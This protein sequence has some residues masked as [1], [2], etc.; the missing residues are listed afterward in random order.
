MVTV[1]TTLAAVAVLATAQMREPTVPFS[2]ILAQWS[3]TLGEVERYLDGADQ[4]EERTV[5]YVDRVNAIGI[6]AAAAVAAAR[7]EIETTEQLLAALGEEAT[8]DR[9]GAVPESGSVIRRRA[10]LQ[11]QLTIL[12][13]R[14]ALADLTVARVAQLEIALSQQ[15]RS[16]FLDRLRRSAPMPLAPNTVAAAVPEFIGQVQAVL[17]SP[18]AWYAALPPDQRTVASLAPPL[19]PLLVAVVLAALAR[20]LLLRWFGQGSEIANPTYARR[21][22]AA[23][24]E[25]AARGI[26]PASVF[27]VLA[28]RVSTGETPFTGHW[29]EVVV[30]FA[31]M[32]SFCLLVVSAPRAILAPEN[33]AYRLTA[34]KPENTRTISRRLIVLATI[35]A[36]DFF[37]ISAGDEAAVSDELESLYLFI[38][39]GAAAVY[40]VL[41][42]S[43]GLWSV[44]APT[45]AGTASKIGQGDRGERFWHW[46]RGLSRLIALFALLA[47]VF[48]FIA[49]GSYLIEALLLTGLIVGVLLLVRGLFRET[50]GL[51]TRSAFVVEQL[52]LRHAARKAMKFWLRAALD[53]LMLFAAVAMILPI[54]GVP[55]PELRRW[56][57]EVLEGIAI[58]EVAISPIDI[59][60][61]VVAF[62]VVLA[63]SRWLRRS[64]SENILPQLEMEPGLQNSLATGV[65]YIGIIVAAALGIAVMGIDLTSLALIFGALSVGIG[66]GLQNIVNNFVSGFVLLI[67]RPIIVGDWVVIGPHEGFVKQINPRSTEIET[68]Q[69]ASVIV[70]NAD[71]IS[72]AVTNWTHTDK[73][74]RIEVRVHVTRSSN[75]PRVR[76]ILLQIANEHPS[77]LVD[78]EPFV[79]FQDFNPSSLEFELRCYTN[80][81]IWKLNIASDMRYEIDRR[82]RAEGIDIPFPRYIVRAEQAQPAADGDHADTAEETLPVEPIAPDRT[83]SGA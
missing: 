43:A 57:G 6:E 10:D 12:Q 65:G 67:E 50:I 76:D 80:D 62:A 55:W 59:L 74:G 66:F 17:A 40:I 13:S 45:A 71:F 52:G 4:T 77:V 18:L 1:F 56:L 70:P 78:P 54:W 29:A 79:L 37:L 48:G 8:P 53:L 9:G 31:W 30:A 41:L 20:G 63:I 24:A 60:L 28:W 39:K 69:R 47:M 27:G 73:V 68:W 16:A 83:A 58:G 5:R 26:V 33:P 75:A 61:A 82:F 7:R 32:I 2:V 46:L 14:A 36:I 11:Q 51:T 38:A 64:L 44:E 22:L 72:Q 3:Q 42:T 34:L 21:L 35:V 15:Y 49:L 19:L 23:V 25:T 81:V